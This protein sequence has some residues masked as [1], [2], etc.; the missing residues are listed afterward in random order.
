MRGTQK[1]DWLNHFLEFIVVVI[2][3]LLAFQLNTC[4]E[5]KKEGKLVEEHIESIVE[6]TSLN[7]SL[8]GTSIKNSERLLSLLDSTIT[9][10]GKDTIPIN[11]VHSLSM[12]LMS[13]DYIYI[14]KNAY[15]SLVQTGDIRFIENST[16]Q[17]DII[18]LYEYYGWL[19][20]L[21]DS[22]RITYL[23]NYM[24]YATQNFDLIS[25]RP[26]KEEVYTNK[27]FRN[28]LSV[29]KYSLNFRLQKQ[30]E[31]MGYMDEFLKNYSTNLEE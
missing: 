11:S 25:Y 13:L 27:L 16:L 8:L 21:D 23:E 2:G 26:Q 24:P 30:V 12:Q 31:V 6:E 7:K 20:G 14:K 5:K 18:S 9:L 15:N 4:S 22:S 19:Q 10:T 3:I 17:N 28:Y 29:Y 1:I